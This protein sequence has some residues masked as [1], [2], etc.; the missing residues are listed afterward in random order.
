M[1]EGLP[2]KIGGAALDAPVVPGDGVIVQADGVD[3]PT[4]ALHHRAGPVV[5]VLAGAAGDFVGL[6]GGVVPA[7]EGGVLTADIGVKFRPHV[8]AAAPGLV[9][10]APVPHVERFFLAVFPAQVGHGGAPGHVAVFHPVGKLLYR[11]A[12]HVAGDIGLTSQFPAQG[13][14]LV[15]AEGVVLGHAAPVGVHDGLALCFGTDAVSPVIGIGKAAARPAQHRHMQLFQGVDHIGA[16]TAVGVG[17]P[18][19]DA[20]AQMLGKMAVD[21]FVDDARRPVGVDDDMGHDKT[22]LPCI[23]RPQRR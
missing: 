7:Q 19:V 2:V 18:A 15:G 11:A 8:A 14:E 17:Q 10:D 22:L 13:H 9:A 23:P 3:D 1:I 12:A 20:A 6:A 5:V 16:Q 21:V 4:G